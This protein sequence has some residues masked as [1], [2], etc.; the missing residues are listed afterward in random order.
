METYIGYS[1]KDRL[2]GAIPTIPTFFLLKYNF[3]QYHYCCEIAVVFF[4]DLMKTS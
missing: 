1:L 2:I 4:I 3:Y